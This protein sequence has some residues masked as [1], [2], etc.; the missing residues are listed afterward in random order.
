MIR[1][2]DTTNM[3]KDTI[4]LLP[5]YDGDGDGTFTKLVRLLSVDFECVVINYPYYRQ[6]DHAYTLSELID[7]LHNLIKDKHLTKFHLLGFSMGGFVATSYSLSFPQDILSLTL[8]SSSTKPILGNSHSFL[9]PLAYYLFKIPLLAKL[10]SLVYTSKILRPLTQ[11]SPLPLPRD[12]FP[13]SEAY[14]VFGTLANVMHGSITTNRDDTVK[15]LICSKQAILFK[16]DLSF[17][18][19]TNATLLTNLGFRVIVKEHGGHATGTDYW[20]QVSI[21]M[22]R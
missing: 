17:P 6:I 21:F 2:I 14:P 8:A 1:I 15:D 10:F 20:K 22:Y 3:T 16:D 13:S 11:V 7:Y 5:G 19:S 9:L 18:A 12:N 4:V